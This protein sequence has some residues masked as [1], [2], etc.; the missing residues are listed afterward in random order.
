MN[1]SAQYPKTTLIVLR[2]EDFE[3]TGGVPAR[4]ER[5][6]EDELFSDTVALADY[7]DW[8]SSSSHGE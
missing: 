4:L 8:I 2:R 6:I 1:R 3:R 7:Q 5:F